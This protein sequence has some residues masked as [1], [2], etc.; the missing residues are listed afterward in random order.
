MPFIFSPEFF[1][2]YS[3]FTRVVRVIA[4]MVRIN[5]IWRHPK[6]HHSQLTLVTEEVYQ[7]KLLCIRA[8][9]KNAFQCELK[10]VLDG[11]SVPVDSLLAKVSPYLDCEGILRVDGRL[12]NAP[13][14]H[15][16][17]HPIIV[18]RGSRF[19]RLLILHI[20]HQWFC[21]STERTLAKF[22]QRYWTS[23]GRAAVKSA[24]YHCQKCR[25]RNAQ[26]QIPLMAA[27]PADRVEPFQPAFSITGI[28]FF[29]PMMV[30]LHRRQ[31][32]RYGCLLTCMTTR[33]VHIEI[34]HS[35]DTSWLL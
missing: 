22:R 24:L 8:V 21:A 20:H 12:N 30:T 2:N 19:T 15:S 23:G 32:K 10:C 16:M 5:K 18:P 35:L 3:S 26:P 17:K 11:R 28:D 4:W 29:C 33:A 9:Q 31:H 25:K 34:C 6:P 7:A 1:E 13:V 14:S 27:L